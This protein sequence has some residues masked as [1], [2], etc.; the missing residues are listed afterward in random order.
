M[1]PLPHWAPTARRQRL[2]SEVLQWSPGTACTAGEK[3]VSRSKG[4]LPWRRI[5]Y[6]HVVGTPGVPFTQGLAIF[7]KERATDLSLCLPNPPHRL[8]VATQG[9]PRLAGSKPPASSLPAAA[10]AG[11]LL[12]GGDPCRTGRWR[13]WE[14]R[15]E[16]RGVTGGVVGKSSTG[17]QRAQICPQLCWFCCL[18]RISD[19][20]CSQ[21]RLAGVRCLCLQY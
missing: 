3:A 2:V 7:P 18:Q 19:I 16:S 14:K 17:I 1:A 20:Q 6:W 13:V 11:R 21:S 10:P 5:C 9:C 4:P 8:L 15:E 12:I